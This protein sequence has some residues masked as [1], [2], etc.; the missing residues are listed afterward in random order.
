MF[1]KPCLVFESQV[2]VVPNGIFSIE[3]FTSVHCISS[4]E[5]L[6]EGSL[7][8]MVSLAHIREWEHEITKH[9][10]PQ[11]FHQNVNFHVKL[12][13]G[14]RCFVFYDKSTFSVLS[15]IFLKK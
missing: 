11:I 15:R 4:D 14:L 6:G 9:K 7:F 5:P 10:L 8:I 1:D 3:K 13:F 12:N 2:E